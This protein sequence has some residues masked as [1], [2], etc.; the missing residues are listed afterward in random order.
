[1]NA[2]KGAGVDGV[3]LQAIKF[4]D[5]HGVENVLL[6]KALEKE[7]IPTLKLEREYGPLADT[8][9]FRTRVQAFLEQMGR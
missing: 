9:R 3:I 7:G 8:G 1:M 5:L 2:A 6:Q 4:C